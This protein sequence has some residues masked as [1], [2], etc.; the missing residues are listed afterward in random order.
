MDTG[1]EGDEVRFLESAIYMSSAP[2]S[3]F[4]PI[5]TDSLCLSKAAMRRPDSIAGEAF[6]SLARSID[7]LAGDSSHH[8]HYHVS[9]VRHWSRFVSPNNSCVRFLD[10]VLP[11]WFC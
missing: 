11:E 8:V 5:D 10:L 6:A 2:T 9:K 4:A 3:H 1:I 7:I